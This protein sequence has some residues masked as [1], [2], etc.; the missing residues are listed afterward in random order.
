[1]IETDVAQQSSMCMRVRN[2]QIGISNVTLIRILRGEKNEP[3]FKLSLMYT[4]YLLLL[5]SF[6]MSIDYLHGDHDTK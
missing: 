5:W 1:M 3:I 2:F 6:E 4:F